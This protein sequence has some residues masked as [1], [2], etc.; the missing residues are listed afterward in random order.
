MEG[1]MCVLVS[2]NKYARLVPDSVCTIFH[3]RRCKVDA[4]THCRT[5]NQ[6]SSG[7]IYIICRAC[8]T[9][10]NQYSSFEEYLQY[11]RSILYMFLV[12]AHVAM[13]WINRRRQLPPEYN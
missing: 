9:R 12:A 6:A 13:A 2:T 5:F 11:S 1:G 8:L 3:Q 4:A 10:K 7:D